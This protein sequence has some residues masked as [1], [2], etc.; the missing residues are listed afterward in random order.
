MQIIC[1]FATYTVFA[2]QIDTIAGDG[3][4]CKNHICILKSW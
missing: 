2:Q 3:H 4:S 1:K